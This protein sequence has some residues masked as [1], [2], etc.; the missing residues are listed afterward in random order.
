MKDIL[1]RNGNGK[2]KMQKFKF[3][4][5]CSTFANP[6]QIKNFL[7]TLIKQDYRGSFETIIIDNGTPSQE[8]YTAC[9]DMPKKINIRLNRIE[10]ENKTCTN[11]STGINIAAQGATGS[12][13]I[14][15]ADPNVLLSYNLLS[16]IDKIIKHDSLI[17]S[18][19]P[20]NDV[21]ISPNGLQQTEYAKMDRNQM[22]AQNEI[23]LKEMGWPCDPLR[24]KLLSGKHRFPPPHLGYDC[25]IAPLS[26]M[27]FYKY[28]QYPTSETNWGIYHDKYLQKLALNLKEQRLQNVRIVHQF[29]RVFKED[30]PQ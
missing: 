7:S 13:L 19:G 8:I 23:L 28:G 21:K 12:Y 15:V 9:C 25:N 11:I 22:S 29:H 14:I 4:I 16:S 6:D 10:P 5:I 18:A 1:A 30:S 26:R 2:K 17:L 27:N 24:L 20:T 3:S